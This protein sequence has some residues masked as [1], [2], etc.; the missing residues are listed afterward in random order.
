M[1]NKPKYPCFQSNIKDCSE[2]K[3]NQQ[4]TPV[5]PASEPE[6]SFYQTNPNWDTATMKKQNKA[7]IK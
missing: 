3:A 2:N 6:S 1:K 4:A 7:N 5:I